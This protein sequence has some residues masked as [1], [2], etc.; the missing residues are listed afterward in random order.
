MAV[1]LSLFAGAGQQFFTNAGVPLAG[2]KIYTYGAGGSTPQ[3]TYTTSAGNIAHSNPIVLDAAGRV[4]GGGEI[5][6]T[7]TL[8]YKFQLETSTGTIVQTLDNVSASIGSAALVSSSGSNLIGFIQAGSGAVARTAQSKMR[9]VVSVKDF[10]A[11]GDGVTDDKAAIQL[12]LNSGA[13]EVVFSAGS[14]Y[15]TD[16]GL[17]LTTAGVTVICTGA[18]IKLKNNATSLAMLFISATDCV[19]DG[20]TWDGNKANGNATGSTY[21]SYNI[22]M[23]A[24]RCTV[25]NIRSINT[26]GIGIKG[27]GNYLSAL[28]NKIQN[29]GHYG[30]FF[31]GSAS[32]SHTGNRAIG[33][34]IDMSDG[35][36]SGGINI[37]QGILFTAGTGQAQTAWELADNNIIGPQTSVTDQAINLAVRGNNGI[38]S[39]NTT[40]YGAMGFSEGGSNTV[41]TGNRF[42]DITG[43][44]AYGI[45]PSGVNMTISGNTVTGAIR[46][47][48]GSVAAMD[49][50]TIT[51]NNIVASTNAINIQVTVGGTGQNI[52]I[53]GNYLQGSSVIRLTRDIKNITISGNVIVGPSDTFASGR[54]IYFD[55]PPAD[56][57]A[58][59]SGNTIVNVQ[60][61]YAVFSAAATTF[62]YLFAIGNNISLAG[63]TVSS[64]VWNAEGSA[65]IGTPVT[66]SANVNPATLGVEYSVINQSANIRVQYG[67]GSPEGVITAGIGS[68]FINKSGGAGTTL[69]VKESGTGNTGWVGK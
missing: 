53:S 7:D 17:T 59:I 4:P 11:V 58:F 2:G 21:N 15:L 14:T 38:V 34:T 16:G 56:V 31:D 42:L 65:V 50:M 22:A 49:G 51:G 44:T 36:I 62:N 27:F 54:G 18:T 9:E 69:Y 40:R 35:I 46:G 64:S 43:T 68:L 24:D 60:R 13:K 45:E 30:V 66:S 33:N 61:P 20:G 19:V 28:N 23:Y 29:T 8:V 5:W 52:V 67:T 1:Y 37:G 55:T 57:Y 10:G 39:N 6:L 32:V 25:K 48:A 47:I 3:A 63:S 26:Y 41:I 12:A